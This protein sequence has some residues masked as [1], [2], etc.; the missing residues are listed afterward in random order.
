MVL[1]NNKCEKHGGIVAKE[2]A[3]WLCRICSSEGINPCHLCGNTAH[4]FGEALM[5]S[6]S[7][8]VCDN[9]LAYVGFDK[10]IR[11]LCNEVN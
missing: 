8:S 6:I 9:S 7:C 4:Y 2:D 3:F 10:N 11:H 1:D 5:Q